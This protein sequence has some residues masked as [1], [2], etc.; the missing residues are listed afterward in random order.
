MRFTFLVTILALALSNSLPG[1]EWPQWRGPE[2]DGVVNGVELPA[3]WPGRLTQKWKVN[4][5]EGHS[6]PIVSGGRIYQFSRLNDEE[7][8]AAIN[9]ATGDVDWRTS[10]AAP[11][12]LNSSA[13]AHG[14][15]PKSTPVISEGKLCTLGIGGILSC[16]DATTGKTLWQKEF[17]KRFRNTW[18]LYGTAMSPIIHDGMLIAH[19][20][21]DGG[22]ALAAFDPATGKEKWSWPGDG[23]GYTSPIIVELGGVIQLVTQTERKTIGL[24][25]DTG[26][27]LWEIPFETPWVQNV[28]TPI[29]HGGALV[30]SGL[31]NPTMALRV[32]K[33][34]GR[35]TTEKL[36]ESPEASMYMNS[37]VL[38]GNFAFG[39][40][41]RNSGQYFCLDAA[42]GAV[43]WKGAP[44]SG[45]NAA[46]LLAGDT[47]L[48]LTD[49]AEL[50]VA[51]VDPERFEKIHEYS[52]A[53]SPTWAHPVLLEGGIVVKD[54]NS[55]TLWAW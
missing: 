31:S 55:L 44:R 5:G 50:T 13:A 11:Y 15:G 23:P 43:L 45:D 38:H 4:V 40:T 47:L 41:N 27:L 36:W 18:P 51:R 3:V 30:V 37:P 54:L 21:G 53:D 48:L 52:V 12:S 7:T 39:F 34:D 24:D 19:V 33:T 46:V 22:G 1:Q 42:S 17:S 8:I 49:E 28:V 9:P 26:S 2:R 6:S 35:W 14:K 25:P 16:F 20:G 10:Y 29:V 32:H